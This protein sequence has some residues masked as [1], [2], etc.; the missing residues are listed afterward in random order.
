MKLPEVSN[1]EFGDIPTLI[2][3]TV[4]GSVGVIATLPKEA[5]Q[6][7]AKL[8][9]KLTTVIK[10][11]GGFSHAEYPFTFLK[12]QSFFL[13]VVTWRS[14]T[15]ERKTIESKNFVDGDLIESFLD[16]SPEKMNEVAKSLEVSVEELTKKI[17]TLQRA[18]H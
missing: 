6:F 4:N 14:F 3:G 1:E 8:Q 11:V 12:L 5:Y 18:I 7:F 9:N 13:T 15:N 17:E 2:Y 10:G 16:L